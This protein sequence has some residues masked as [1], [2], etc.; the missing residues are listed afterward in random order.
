MSAIER[1]ISYKVWEACTNLAAVYSRFPAYAHVRKAPASRLPFLCPPPAFG[2]AHHA[3]V[4]GIFAANE[5]GENVLTHHY[6]NIRS[7]LQL[8]PLAS[9]GDAFLNFEPSITIERL[10]AAGILQG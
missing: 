9:T 6:I 4:S 2:Y 10:T 7:P 5:G 3:I 1:C 8:S